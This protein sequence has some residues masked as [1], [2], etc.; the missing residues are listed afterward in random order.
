MHFFSDS[1]S[2]SCDVAPYDVPTFN[3]A[4]G[5]FDEPMHMYDSIPDGQQTSFIGE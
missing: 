3:K 4:K 2:S 5:K 1:V